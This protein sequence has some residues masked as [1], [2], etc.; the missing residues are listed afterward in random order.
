MV[1]QQRP[2]TTSKRQRGEVECQAEVFDEAWDEYEPE[3]VEKAR[4]PVPERQASD[5]QPEQEPGKG[6]QHQRDCKRLE[7]DR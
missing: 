3:P 2:A 1:E 7:G 4:A 5:D 6:D